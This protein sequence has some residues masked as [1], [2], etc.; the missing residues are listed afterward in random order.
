MAAGLRSTGALVVESRANGLRPA[1]IATP[2]AST[3]RYSTGSTQSS[4]SPNAVLRRCS[5]NPRAIITVRTP[6]STST[7]RGRRA[8]GRS[9]PLWL[10]NIT[11]MPG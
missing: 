8:A 6:A 1:S 3:P 2:S 5:T 10:A 11:N 9:L 7:P 4:T